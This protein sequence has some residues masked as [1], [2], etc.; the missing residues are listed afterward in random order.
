M[1]ATK[2]LGRND[3][4]PCGSGKKYKQCCMGKTL[5]RSNLA[6]PIG[7]GLLVIAA[8]VA[9]GFLIGFKTGIGVGAVGALVVGIFLSVRD[10][11]PPSGRGGAS[12]INFGN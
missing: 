10:P 1:A 11:P 8:G 7:L 4:C 3:R 12:N 6:L 9:T 5:T 2:A